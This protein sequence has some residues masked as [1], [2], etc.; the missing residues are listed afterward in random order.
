MNLSIST[1]TIGDTELV[2]LSGEL[3]LSGLPRAHDA[4]VR[5]GRG[6]ARSI[7]LDLDG[8]TLVDEPTLGAVVGA[9]STLVTEQR[10]CAIVANDPRLTARLSTLGVPGRVGLVGSAHDIA[11]DRSERHT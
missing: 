4:I 7:A 5:C 9:L 11:S 10:R 2:A 3:D 6:G 1:S 8:V